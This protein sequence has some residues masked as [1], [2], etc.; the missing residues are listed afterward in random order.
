MNKI[1]IG[2]RKDSKPGS[3]IGPGSYNPEKADSI[4]MATSAKPDFARSPSR[5]NIQV[6]AELGPGYYETN[7]NFG[8]NSP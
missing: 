6:S 8:Q 1:T 3:Y 4:V 2:S 7:T 5:K